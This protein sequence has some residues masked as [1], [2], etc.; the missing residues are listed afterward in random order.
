MRPISTYGASKLGGE[1]LISA[2]ATCSAC[3]VCASASAMLS[4]RARPMASAS[5]F[6]AGSGPI[7]TRLAI[8]GD[9]RQTKSYIHV[10]DVVA[11]VLCA[12]DKA[13]DDFAVFNVATGDT[14]TVKE[15]ADL[16]CVV[17]GLDPGQM[18]YEFSGGNK[19]WKGDVPWSSSTSRVFLH[20]DG[21][22]H[23]P[24]VRHCVGRLRR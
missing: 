7:S 9:G 14:M 15:I 6:C 2:Y 3:A 19:G 10:L 24:R 11:A 21:A 23:F 22:A 20:L 5:I 12:H 1:A 13:R 17:V 8:L 4:A 16:A 18:H